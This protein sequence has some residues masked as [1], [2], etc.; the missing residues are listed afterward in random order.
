MQTQQSIDSKV[1]SQQDS[2]VTAEF[3]RVFA[4]LQE[5]SQRAHVELGPEW[6]VLGGYI[7]HLYYTAGDKKFT[8]IRTEKGTG[9]GLFLLVDTGSQDN[10]EVYLDSDGDGIPEFFGKGLDLSK[11]IYSTELTELEKLPLEVLAKIQPSINSN[12]AQGV[13]AGREYMIAQEVK[14]LMPRR[15]ESAP[16]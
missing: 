2:N 1:V 4:P 14:R 5:F 11:R 10:S 13:N 8:A 9:K 7:N 15:T 12:Y 16:K 6:I 3:L